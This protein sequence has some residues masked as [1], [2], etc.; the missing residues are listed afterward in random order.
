MSFR[1]KKIKFFKKKKK[2]EEIKSKKDSKAPEKTK[3][4]GITQKS[5]NNASNIVIQHEINGEMFETSCPSLLINENLIIDEKACESKRI[6]PTIS[7][8]KTKEYKEDPKEIEETF[9]NSFEDL[10]EEKD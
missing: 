4:N 1:I 9:E 2:E 5:L 3:E 7:Q 8:T 10:E 6:T